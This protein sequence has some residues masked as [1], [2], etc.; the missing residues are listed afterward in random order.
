MEK[1]FWPFERENTE[2]D[3]EMFKT[4]VL[5][6]K[7]QLAKTVL[8]NQFELWVEVTDVCKQFPSNVCVFVLASDQTDGDVPAAAIVG[9]VLGIIILVL[10]IVIVYTCVKSRRSGSAAV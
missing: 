4:F 6:L 2:S 10:V 7:V 1:W 9:A 5:L 8:D 3:K